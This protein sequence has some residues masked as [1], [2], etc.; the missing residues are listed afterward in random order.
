MS[1]LCLRQILTT[2]LELLSVIKA[3]PILYFDDCQG[4][5]EKLLCCRPSASISDA[6]PSIWASNLTFLH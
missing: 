2:D 4:A 6:N 3:L 5:A 1:L